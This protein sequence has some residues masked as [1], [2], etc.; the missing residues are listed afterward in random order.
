MT[1]PAVAARTLGGGDPSWHA[2]RVRR[3]VLLLALAVACGG[4]AP[5]ATIAASSTGLADTSGGESDA[6]GQPPDGPG[7]CGD[8]VVD[9]A[10]GESCDF[11]PGNSDH[12]DCTSYCRFGVCGDGLLRAGEECD[13]GNQLDSDGCRVDCT[14][15]RCGDGVV[16]AGEACDD[17][18]T[19]DGDECPAIC[20]FKT[21][22]DGVVQLGEDCDDGNDIDGDACLG[23]C[24]HAACGDGVVQ[25]GVE[26]CDDGNADDFDTC[27]AACVAPSCDDQVLNGFE[28]DLDCGGVYC[29]GCALGQACMSNLDCQDG[30]CVDGGCSPPLP[31]MPPNCAPAAVGLAQAWA[32]IQPA[33]GCHGNGA[34]GLKFGDAD[35]FRDNTVGLLPTTAAIPLVT[36]FE[37]GASYL[38]YKLLDQQ[39]HV[40]GGRGSRMP[41]AKALGDAQICTLINWVD[42]GAD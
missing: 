21:C 15:P 3:S 7:S 38:I 5:G 1:L 13:D 32:A 10:A 22:G 26:D 12:G 17:G 11:G 14:L 27:T 41:I 4:E 9:G 24:S 20:S 37:P 16:Q 19:I 2:A 6:S 34:G 30:I 25:V 28:S 29:D 8:G 39:D 23:D 18:N 36:P 42:S 33:C 31:L 35:S 40:P